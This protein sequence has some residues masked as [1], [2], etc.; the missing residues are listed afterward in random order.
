MARI[1]EG[2]IKFKQSAIGLW[3]ERILVLFMAV[4]CSISGSEEEPWEDGAV[5]TEDTSTEHET[6]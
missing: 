2:Y 5:M 4:S 1:N 6:H 3:N